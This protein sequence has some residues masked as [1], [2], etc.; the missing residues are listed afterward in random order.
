MLYVCVCVLRTVKVQFWEQ[1]HYEKVVQ[2]GLENNVI[3]KRLS[4]LALA[5]LALV[6]FLCFLF[7]KSRYDKLYSV[8]EVLEFFGDEEKHRR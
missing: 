8:L 2:I 7:Y 1:C 3:M 6:S 4:K 5:L